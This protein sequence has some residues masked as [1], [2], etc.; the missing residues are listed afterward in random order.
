VHEYFNDTHVPGEEQQ[1]PSNSLEYP[2][3]DDFEWDEQQVSVMEQADQDL[4]P[5]NSKSG[6]A[7]D[8]ED[9]VID[10]M[11]SLTVDEKE[12]GHLG[13]ASGGSSATNTWPSSGCTGKKEHL[14]CQELT[15]SLLDPHLWL[16]LYTNNQIRIDIFGIP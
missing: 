12:G 3:M 9:N 15:G 1:H 10:C 11:A 2:P 6:D 4:S 5:R 14:H 16:L 8:T 13:V 7:G